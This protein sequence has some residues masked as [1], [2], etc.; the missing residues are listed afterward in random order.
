MEETEMRNTATTIVLLLVFLSTVCSVHAYVYY[1]EAEDC[2][3]DTSVLNAAGGIWSVVE[4][5]NVSGEK[6]MQYFG[7]HVGANTSLLYTLPD[8]DDNPGQ[9]MIWIR[10]LMPDGGANS[11]FFYVSTDGGGKW[12]PQ[13]TVAA[14]ENPDW[15]WESWA[16]TT[17]FEKGEGNV[18]RISEREDANADLICI[19]NDGAA[20][21]LEE[22]LVWLEEWEAKQQAVEPIHKIATT[23]GNIRISNRR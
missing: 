23:W 6:Y 11:F 17:P 19:R 5:E 2:D 20:P 15:K 21:S 16:P 10:C 1:V 3:P 13:Q 14:A 8:I 12:G 9:C 7:P 22:Y 4:D 18:L